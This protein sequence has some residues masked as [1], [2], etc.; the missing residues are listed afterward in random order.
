MKRFA[1]VSRAVFASAVVAVAA[2]RR[3]S[4]ALALNSA[5]AC[6]DKGR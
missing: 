3:S 4:M 5:G 6:R 2:M 1:K